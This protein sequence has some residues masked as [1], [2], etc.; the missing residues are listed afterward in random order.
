MAEAENFDRLVD[1][2]AERVKRRL[3]AKD[4]AINEPCTAASPS[5]PSC[6]PTCG[7]CSNQ[8]SCGTYQL[9]KG[10]ATRVTPVAGPR[11]SSDI[12]GYIDHT[13]LKADA[14]H[15]ELKKLCEEACQYNFA[16]VCVNSANIPAAVRLLAGCQ[17]VPIAVIG[18][19]LGA[20]L[21]NTKAYEAREAVRQGAKEIDMVINIGALKSRDYQL[22]EDDIRAVVDASRP[23]PVKVILETSQLT[24]DEKVIA[25]ALSKAAGAAFVKTSTGFGG[26]GATAED[27]ALMRAVVGPDMGVKASGGVRNQEDALKMLAAG[28]DRIGASAS[29]AIVTGKTANTKY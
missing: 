5:S 6:A 12:A 27:V 7:Q 10:G 26:G 3:S 22:V 9:V 28:A 24:R 13:L 20:G 1:E 16:T 25:C 17:T 14:T 23:A 29:V 21:T 15:A 2:I 4:V 19:P 18:F 8:G 11:T